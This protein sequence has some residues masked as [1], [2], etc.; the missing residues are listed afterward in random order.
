MIAPTTSRSAGPIGIAGEPIT[1]RSVLAQQSR[2]LQPARDVADVLGQQPQPARQL[3][4]WSPRCRRR[5]PRDDARR[6]A[7]TM[8]CTPRH[9]LVV[10]IEA[11]RRGRRGSGCRPA[12]ERP[13][14][15]RRSGPPATTRTPRAETPE[16][17]PSPTP[18]R[19]TRDAP[20]CRRAKAHS[21]AASSTAPSRAADDRRRKRDAR[22]RRRRVE[23]RERQAEQAQPDDDAQRRL[24]Q[25]RR[26]RAASDQP[27]RERRPERQPGEH[28]QQAGHDRAARAA[29]RAARGSRACRRYRAGRSRAPAMVSSATST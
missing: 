16:P 29:A 4:P 1:R 15:A 10:R 3:I 12:R 2:A 11:A 19:R 21:T 14:P 9:L 28:A 23:D 27:A 8:I 26:C 13:R 24:E 25:R 6:V 5:R 17:P 18:A 22:P 7:S 20:I